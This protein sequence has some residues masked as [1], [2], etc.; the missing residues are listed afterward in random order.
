MD[1][2][3]GRGDDRPLS[4]GAAQRIGGSDGNEFMTGRPPLHNTDPMGTPSAR[5]HRGL[6]SDPRLQQQFTISAREASSA[7]PPLPRR[8]SRPGERTM[9]LSRRTHVA[10]KDWMFVGLLVAALGV[11]AS[12][13][14]S[15]RNQSGAE[16]ASEQPGDDTGATTVEHAMTEDDNA[17]PASTAQATSGAVRATEL[18]SE[19]LGAE[20]VASG[21]V[22]GNTP[23]RVARGDADVEYTLRMPGYEPQLVRVGA[24]SPA[25][26]HVTLQPKAAAVAPVTSGISPRAP[27]TGP[28]ITPPSAAPAEATP[29][30]AA[31]AAAAPSTPSPAPEATGR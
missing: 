21:A 8:H 24:N 15:Y 9:I 1:A 5:Q 12:M 30:T 28:A 7:P 14:W 3:G 18:R 2:S 13:L 22:V 20:V 25:T 6:L 19:P 29:A 26:I 31:A 17:N 11:T 16:A 27:G 23:V 10:T 4:I